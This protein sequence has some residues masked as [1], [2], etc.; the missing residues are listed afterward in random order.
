[1]IVVLP[2]LNLSCKF[3]FPFTESCAWKVIIWS[4]RSL[5]WKHVY[6]NIDLVLIF[7]I[8]FIFCSNRS[9]KFAYFLVCS[10]GLIYW[11]KRTHDQLRLTEMG[12]YRYW[13]WLRRIA[14]WLYRR[15]SAMHLK[16]LV[17]GFDFFLWNKMLQIIR[18]WWRSRFGELKITHYVVNDGNHAVFKLISRL[19]YP[20]QWGPGVLFCLHGVLL[21][22]CPWRMFRLVTNKAI[23]FT[24]CLVVNGCWRFCHAVGSSCF[25]L[26]V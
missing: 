6:F 14:R 24:R 16:F 3:K 25:E 15:K 11:V 19:W 17:Q 9:V 23:R 20:V 5:N 8:K 4:V 12:P 21:V 26:S 22:C 10:W 2:S 18:I 1:M 7:R 13:K